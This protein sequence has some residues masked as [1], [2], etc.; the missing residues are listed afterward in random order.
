VSEG[1]Y[2]LQKRLVQDFSVDERRHNDPQVGNAVEEEMMGEL[3]G[4]VF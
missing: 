3:E 4:D 2:E 1:R